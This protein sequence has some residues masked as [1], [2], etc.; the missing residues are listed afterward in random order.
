[1]NQVEI[2]EKL[3]GE[4]VEKANAFFTTKWLNYKN[5]VQNTPIKIFK[6]LKPVD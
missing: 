5:M 6:D 4:A 1:M 2:A 3:V